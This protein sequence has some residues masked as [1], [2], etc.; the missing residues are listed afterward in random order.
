MQTLPIDGALPDILAALESHLAVVVHAE[1]GA[2]KTT[3]VP[4]ALLE[5]RHA[6]R[7]KVLVLEPRRLAARLAASYVASLAGCQVGGRVGYRVRFDHASGPATRLEFITEALLTRR[8][9][10]EPALDDVTI[11]VFDEFH[12]R[13]LSTDLGLALVR[14]LQATRRPDLK[15][16]VMSATIAADAVADYLGGVP[17]VR[18]PGRAYPLTIEHLARPDARP[19]ADQVTSAVRRTVDAGVDG[20]VLVFLPGAAEIRRAQASCAALAAQHHL[21]TLALHGDLPPREQDRAV[22]P[23][24][25]YKLILSTNVAETSVTI[26]G[27]TT[28]I[29]SGLARIPT[30]N[31]WS[32]LA[33]LRVRPVSRASATQRAGRAGRTG[34][35]RVYRLYTNHDFLARPAFDRPEIVRSDLTEVVLA[36]AAL[37]VTELEELNWLLTP[38]AP[39]LGAARELLGRLG[40]LGRTHEITPLGRELL[41]LPVHPRLARIIVAASAHGLGREGCIVAAVLGERDMRRTRGAARD[42]GPSDVLAL[43]DLFREAEAH[44]FAPGLLERAEL[45]PGAVHG[46]ARVVSQLERLVARRSRPHTARAGNEEATLLHC[47]LAG[48]PDRVAKRVRPTTHQRGAPTRTGEVEQLELLM[49]TGGRARLARESVVRDSE[50]VVA[51]DAEEASREL[52]I[53]R[54]ASAIE[55]EALVAL[56]T[57]LLR[58]ETVVE[59]N[60]KTE[61]V[62]GVA[63]LRYGGLV[64]EERRQGTLDP[65]QAGPVLLAAARTAGLD[66]FIDAEGLGQLNARIDFLRQCGEAH[67]WPTLDE[68]ALDRALGEACATRS[69]FAELRRANVQSALESFLP[70]GARAKLDQLAPARIELPG[71]R[72]LAVTYRTGQP[73]FIESRLQDFFGMAKG[74]SVARGR[75]ALTIHLL[76][77][78]Q[79][80]LQVTSDLASFWDTHYPE[81]RRALARRYPKHDWPEDP[82]RAKPPAP[83]KGGRR[84]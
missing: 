72:R 36:L 7:G 44:H 80:P 53:V 57:D 20:H 50:Y 14:R 21:T 47:I 77:P 1:P 19:L 68:S 74:P 26:D 10:D 29:D 27:V 48:Y 3:R 15:L 23:S 6:G 49:A 31:P 39:A 65:T 35:G 22:R 17:I 32:G 76:A 61:H 25:E 16:V 67:D 9:L 63:R 60:S 75:V 51:V 58:D 46:I 73:P 59:W 41:R 2:G 28:V 45:N 78:S 43:C 84:G 30:H 37:G 8:L 42:S 69:S 4:L 64:L 34:S 11:V 54:L 83:N 55:V 62:D 18:V 66:T 13:H 81:L 38:P 56:E 82:R 52:P 12:E 79:R 5:S 33:A 71:G 70:P 40:A 24:A